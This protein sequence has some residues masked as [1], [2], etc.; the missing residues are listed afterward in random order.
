MSSIA[1]SADPGEPSA[2]QGTTVPGD[3]PVFIDYD[4]WPEDQLHAALRSA[5]VREIRSAVLG[6]RGTNI[7]LAATTWAQRAGCAAKVQTVFCST[8]EESI[9]Y[10]RQVDEA[11][12]VAMF[13]TCAVYTRENDIFFGNPDTSPFAVRQIMRLDRMQLAASPSL[14]Q[15][16][17]DQVLPPHWRIACHPAPA[18]LLKDLPNPV[19]PVDSNAQ[20]AIDCASGRTELCVTTETAR[21]I[22]RLATL[23]SFGSPPM[24][25]FGGLPPKSLTLLKEVGHEQQLKVREP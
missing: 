5:R 6:P 19:V 4:L 15:A 23:H 14:A 24:V 1:W 13:W 18:A 8:P 20:A 11:G 10:A 3:L 12:V 21:D 22:S 16:I 2:R 7:H 25:F 17:Q 9:R